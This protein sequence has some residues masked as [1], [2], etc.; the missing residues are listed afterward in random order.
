MATIV[1]HKDVLLQATSPRV[2]YNG[3][4]DIE[5]ADVLDTAGTKPTNNADVTSANTAAAIAGQGT[6]ATLNSVGSAQILS[7]AITAAKTALAAINSS[8]GNLN[9][10]TVNAI[11]MNVANLAAI[12][13]NLGTVTAGSITGTSNIDITGSAKFGGS[14]YVAGA[15][16]SA[17][18]NA[19]RSANNGLIAYNATGGGTC[20]TASGNYG[21]GFNA[22]IPYGYGFSA[23]T[24]T[25]TAVY[26][27]TGAGGTALNCDG[28]MT[29]SDTA[30]VSNFNADRIDYY[31]AGN[32]T[33]QVA[34]SNGTM[35]TNLNANKVGGYDAAHLTCWMT[36]DSGSAATASSNRIHLISTVSGVESYVSGYTVNIRA[37]SDKRRKKDIVDETWGLEFIRSLRPKQF[38]EKKS[39]EKLCHGFISQ[40][41]EE[42]IQNN[43]DSL[44]FIHPDGIYGSEYSQLDGPL[45]LAIQ[46]LADAVDLI[47]IKLNKLN[48]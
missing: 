36:G 33:G 16:H 23:A 37:I 8:T 1:N 41:I 27:T 44:C 19:S 6:L 12:S 43:K 46:Q 38:R 35:C 28:K 4:G 22:Y 7:G 3:V 5:W 17:V 34:V 20:I 39:P 45:T 15:Y 31:H 18:F 47:N 2:P 32:S 26:C 42:I 10:Y 48:N 13:A 21:T 14:V 9:A 24:D 30:L 25:G 11:N 29:K 40:E